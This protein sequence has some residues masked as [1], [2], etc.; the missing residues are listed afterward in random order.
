MHRGLG[1][2]RLPSWSLLEDYYNDPE[3]TVDDTVEEETGRMV[4]WETNDK[5]LPWEEHATEL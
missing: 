5:P 4:R 3:D 1:G 2:V